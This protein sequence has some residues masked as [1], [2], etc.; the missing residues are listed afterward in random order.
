MT[1]TTHTCTNIAAVC[2]RQLLGKKYKKTPT[3]WMDGPQ[4]RKKK[5]IILQTNNA[6]WKWLLNGFMQRTEWKETRSLEAYV[7]VHQFI[8]SFDK[9]FVN[10]PHP[11]KKNT[12]KKMDWRK[13]STT[14]CTNERQ[15][16]DLCVV[17]MCFIFLLTLVYFYRFICSLFSVYFF[18]Y[19]SVFTI[20]ISFSIFHFLCNSYGISMA[21]LSM[22]FDCDQ[23]WNKCEWVRKML[24]NARIK[25]KWMSGIF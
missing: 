16:G 1:Q 3:H 7:D 12:K 13:F 18:I 22:L 24:F 11:P 9:T 15:L 10:P 17:F 6:E 23:K 4:K 21:I 19:F 25:I 8:Y 2:G 20:S 14:K 5:Y